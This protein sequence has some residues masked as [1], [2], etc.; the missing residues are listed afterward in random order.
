MAQSIQEH[1]TGLPPDRNFAL[2]GNYFADA[3]CCLSSPRLRV[4]AF[5]V[6]GK[7]HAA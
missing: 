2:T 4:I 1:S 6:A 3:G 7:G 5:F